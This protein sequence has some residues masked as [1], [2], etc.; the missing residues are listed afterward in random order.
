MATSRQP[1]K[2]AADFPQAADRLLALPMDLGRM[3][4][5]RGMVDAAIARF[6]RIDVL[7]NNAGYGIIG[8][9]EEASETEIRQVFEINV[10]GLLRVTRA[11]LA[12]HALAA[13]RATS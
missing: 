3:D 7:V 8:A 1:Q 11:V 10:F 12:R 9:V 5:I 6:G 13:Q 4:E 2:V